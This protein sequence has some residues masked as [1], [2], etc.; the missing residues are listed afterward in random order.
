MNRRSVHWH[1]NMTIIVSQISHANLV[2]SSNSHMYVQL[3][4]PASRHISK[5]QRNSKV[6]VAEQKE[7]R[8]ESSRNLPAGPVTSHQ[9][10]NNGSS[11]LRKIEVVSQQ[12]TYSQ[13][14]IPIQ[15]SV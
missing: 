7:N 14:G 2:S 5:L 3:L 12:D 13:G 10:R 11:G 4:R 15:S 6:L 9:K 8:R 1:S